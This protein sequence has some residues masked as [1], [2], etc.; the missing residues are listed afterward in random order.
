MLAGIP[1][2]ECDAWKSAGCG[3][4]CYEARRTTAASHASSTSDWS[5]MTT[6]TPTIRPAELSDL[7]G[8]AHIYSSLWCNYLRNRGDE[9]DALLASRFNVCMQLERSP[10]TLVA[11]HEGKIVAACF[12]GFFDHG[13][14]QSN[15]LWQD[16]YH[17]LLAQATKRAETADEDL[18][19]SLFG[20]SREKETADRFAASGTDYAQAQINL[21][22]ILPEWQGH[23]LG[24]LLIERARAAMREAGRTKFFLMTDNQ[25]DYAF[26]DHLGMTRI[27]EDHSQD[28]GDGFTVYMY[29]DEA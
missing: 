5:I 10:I 11:E 27:A 28:T 12:V 26:Y 6:D 7:D 2:A 9:A 1:Q 17:D 19:G 16:C 18:E 14:P 15:P 29:G 22:I 8:I 25:S 23:G 3:T 4:S 21:I 13:V 20:D 24:R